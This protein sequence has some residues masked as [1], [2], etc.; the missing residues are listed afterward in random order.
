[1]TSL[2]LIL[3]VLALV[4][5]GALIFVLLRAN[6]LQSRL[7]ELLEER[8]RL[9]ASLEHARQSLESE[10]GRSRDTLAA[11]EERSRQA[12]LTAEERFRD[13]LS[14]EQQRVQQQLAEQ[15]QWITDQTRHFE[16]SVL[17]AAA[18]LMEERGKAFAELNQKEVQTVVTPFKEQLA[19]FRQ[20]VDHIYAEDIRERGSLKAQIETL[21]GMNQAMS[22]QA[23]RLANAL[24]VTSKS[25]GDWGETILGKILED[26]GLRKGHEYDLQL[27]VKGLDG[28]RLIPDA[29]IHLPES[30]QLVIDSKVSNKAWTE[31]CAVTDE[32]QREA[33][34][35]EHLAS[36]RG[37]IKN[38][39]GK[40]YSD[41][42]ELKTVDFV[43]MFVPVEAALLTAFVKDPALYSDAYRARIVL[44]TPSTLMAV[45]K[46]VEGIWTFQKRKESADEIAEAGRKLYE[47]L[48]NFAQSFQNLG[49]AIQQSQAAFEQAEGQLAKGKGNAIRLAE[50]M[51]ELGVTPAAGKQMPPALLQRALDEG[52]DA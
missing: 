28:E 37:H 49:R 17:A 4:L 12:Q 9:N 42:P 5:L 13:A 2:T 36:L 15:K 33:L 27:V 44:V 21:T 31:Y 35:R 32:V 22:M 16:T 29:V 25:V 19:E 50:Q 8:S 3:A 46:L 20:R 26:S 24:T 48:T 30:R 38:L 39:S 34:L 52:G 1:M 40:R 47:K 11:Q 10:Q 43:L 23:E 6:P 14:K 41:A 7:E 18:R 51:K 45:V